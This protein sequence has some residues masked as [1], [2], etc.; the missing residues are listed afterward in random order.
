MHIVEPIHEE[1]FAKECQCSVS[2]RRYLDIIVYRARRCGQEM[3]HGRILSASKEFNAERGGCGS[4]HRAGISS[5]GVALL[6]VLGKTIELGDDPKV[7]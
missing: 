1:I 4:R 2:D 6:K 7:A 5:K 3:Y